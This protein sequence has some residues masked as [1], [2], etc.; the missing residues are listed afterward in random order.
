MIY[1]ATLIAECIAGW[2]LLS[3]L[4]AWCWIRTFGER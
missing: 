3:M 2:C 1:Y 4:A